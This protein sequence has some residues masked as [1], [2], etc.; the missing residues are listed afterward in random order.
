MQTLSR[1]WWSQAASSSAISSNRAAR[2]PRVP[3]VSSRTRSGPSGPASASARGSR[4]S[5]V[6]AR[7]A[8]RPLARAWP[9]WTTTPAAPMDAALARV[10][11]TTSRDRSLVTGLALAKLTR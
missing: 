8:A 9:A 1:G 3:A 6:V 7:P 11:A 4:D 10:A 5:R 2:A